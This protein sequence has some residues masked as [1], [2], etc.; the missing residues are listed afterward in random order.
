MATTELR[1]VWLGC[2]RCFADTHTGPCALVAHLPGKHNQKDHGHAGQ[3]GM[4]PEEFDSRLAAAMSGRDLEGAT[5]INP[6]DSAVRKAVADYGENGADAANTALRTT[7]GHIDESTDWRAA[8]VVEG[9]D[10][11]FAD[12]PTLSKDAVVARGVS[13]VNV[14]FGGAEPAVGMEWVDHGFVSTSASPRA[15]RQFTG[16]D[17]GANG[18]QMRILVPKG[19]KAISSRDLLAGEQEVI[20]PRGLKFRVVRDNG[21]DFDGIRQLDVEVLGPS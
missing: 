19:T 10:A 14:T 5:G 21:L 6:S 3:S 13:R 20:L 18:L 2:P 16:A 1:E 8:P 4:G 12:A 7:G 15:L 11:A 17:F 9:M